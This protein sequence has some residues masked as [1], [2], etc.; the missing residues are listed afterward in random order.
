MF[1]GPQL[2]CAFLRPSRIDGAKHAAAILKLLV[3][4]LRQQWPAVRIVFR[5]D[6]GFCRQRILNYCERAAVNY[7]IGPARNARL[8]QATE[9][10]ELA[11]KDAFEQ[12][13]VKQRE[14]GDS[15]AYALQRKAPRWAI[16][17]RV[18]CAKTIP[19]LSSW[20]IFTVDLS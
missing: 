13:G 5:G 9:F 11:M 8:Q 3:K 4:R 20:M 2:L 10:M 17:R 14:V 1:C 18:K 15:S 19:R 12:T 6:S 7:I 16:Q